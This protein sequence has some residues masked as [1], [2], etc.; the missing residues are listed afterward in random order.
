MPKGDYSDEFEIDARVEDEGTEPEVEDVEAS[1]ETRIKKLKDELAQVKKEKQENM[2][3]WQRAKADYVNL[4]KRSEV[5]AKNAREAGVT[6]A[7]EALLPAYDAIERAKE[8]GDIPEGF[9]AIV[10]QLEA[11]FGSLGLVAVGELGEAFDPNLHEAY[12]QD[13][14]DDKAKDDTVTA[15][16]EK[17]WKQG[18]RVIRPAKVRVGHFA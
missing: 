14:V 17:G 11:A 8:H 10:K 13:A 18:D 5:D 3:G 15:V 16:L 9:Q 6:K 2:D 12:G 1:A 4:L 7:V